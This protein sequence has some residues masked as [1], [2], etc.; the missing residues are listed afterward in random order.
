[1]TGAAPHPSI[2][3]AEQWQNASLGDYFVNGVPPEGYAGSMTYDAD[4]GYVV[5]FG[6]C[7]YAAC[8]DNT[9]WGTTATTG[10]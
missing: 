10:S 8:P 1:M 5:Y 9:T 7:D 3:S 6:G 2:S 4:H